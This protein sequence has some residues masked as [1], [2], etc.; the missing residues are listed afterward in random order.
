MRNKISNKIIAS[1]MLTA[2]LFSNSM[3]AVSAMENVGVVQYGSTNKPALRDEGDYSLK[4][5]GDVSFIKKNP[6]ISISL[7]DSDVKQVLRMFADKAG[8]NIVF[9]IYYLASFSYF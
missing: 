3:L 6:L 8:M 1:L 7:R 9:K 2:L 4:L 5:K